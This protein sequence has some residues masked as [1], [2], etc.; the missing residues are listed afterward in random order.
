MPVL[1]VAVLEVGVAPVGRGVGLRLDRRVMPFGCCC[2][3][4]GH[5]TGRERCE[6]QPRLSSYADLIVAVLEV[7]VAPVGSG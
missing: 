3:R 6:A 4:S 1:V 2:I 5:G 7:G